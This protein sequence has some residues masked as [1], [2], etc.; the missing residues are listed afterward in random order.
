MA[1][2]CVDTTGDCYT[3]G[4]SF[5]SETEIERPDEELWT[6]DG[7]LRALFSG[8]SEVQRPYEAAYSDVEVVVLSDGE[9]VDRERIGE[10]SVE[11]GD[12]SDS[13]CIDTLAV[14]PFSVTVDRPPT[15]I[16]ADC[17]EFDAICDYGDYIREYV[18]QGE[19]SEEPGSIR[20]DTWDYRERPCEDGQLG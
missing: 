17:A 10:V 1:S 18:Y 20:D 7:G 6:V 19:S 3:W 9:I 13:E 8:S 14:E 15:R 11:D 12:S 4:L 5:D 16:T 2:G